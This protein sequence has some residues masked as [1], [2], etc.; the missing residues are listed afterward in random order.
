MD[1]R[2][3]LEGLCDAMESMERFLEE[4]SIDRDARFWARLFLE[5]IVTNILK[6]AYSDCEVHDIALDVRLKPED[7]VLQVA[8][9]GRAFNPLESPQPDL[10]VP[11][12]ERPVGGLGVHLI[13]KLASR[14]D[15]VRAGDKNVLTAYIPRSPKD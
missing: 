4:S 13:K 9:D 10:D 2:N 3:D 12:E 14:L 11:C 7:V 5:E 1:L 6:Y 8:D 15:Y